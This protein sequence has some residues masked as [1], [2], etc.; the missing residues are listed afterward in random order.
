MSETKE[1]KTFEERLSRLGEIVAKVEAGTLPL[2]E[3]MALFE[4]GNGLILSLQKELTE[5]KTKI[6]SVKDKKE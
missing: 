3:A 6:A 4:E 5:A 2:E 1:T